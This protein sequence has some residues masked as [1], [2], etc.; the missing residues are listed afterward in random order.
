MA[1]NVFCLL[2]W[3]LCRKFCLKIDFLSIVKIS[4]RV[5]LRI[6]ALETMC[7]N[8]TEIITGKVRK[9][10]IYLTLLIRYIR[11]K[12]YRSE[13]RMSLFY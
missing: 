12:G 1:L 2:N 7:R 4:K 8:M 5:A 9:M 10:T 6:A 3:N 13:S 11:F